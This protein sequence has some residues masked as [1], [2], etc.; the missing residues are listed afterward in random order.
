MTTQM[1]SPSAQNGDGALVCDFVPHRGLHGML[2]LAHLLCELFVLLAH[3]ECGRLRARGHVH[4]HVH[5]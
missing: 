2:P 5:V 3:L 1:Q 4:V